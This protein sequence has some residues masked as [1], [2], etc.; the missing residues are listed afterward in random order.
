V[1]TRL[2]LRPR[3]RLRAATAPAQLSLCRQPEDGL[4]QPAAL[5]LLLIP[6]FDVHRPRKALNGNIDKVIRIL[7][8]NFQIDLF[9]LKA[10]FTSERLKLG[11]K[12][13]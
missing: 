10:G 4:L 6:V 1:S 11:Y 13:R 7:R 12:T 2:F 9:V 5:A 3:V 8:R